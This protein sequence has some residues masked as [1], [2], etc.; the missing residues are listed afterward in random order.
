MLLQ[1]L[2]L[3]IFDSMKKLNLHPIFYFSV[4]FLVLIGVQSYFLYNTVLLKEGEIKTRAK[5]V[6]KQAEKKYAFFDNS[7]REESLYVIKRPKHKIESEAAIRHELE[8]YNDSLQDVLH[9]FAIEQYEQSGLRL[10][11]KKELKYIYNNIEKDTIVPK[12]IVILETNPKPIHDFLLNESTWETSYL[13]TIEDE[14]VTYPDSKENTVKQSM[15]NY[16]I[17]QA[18]YYDVLNLKYIVFKELWSLFFVSVLLMILM[19]YLYFQ[20]YKKYKEQLSQVQLLH[21]TIDNISHEFKT[22]LATLRIATK[23]LRIVTTTETIDIVDRQ[24]LRLEN[25]LKPLNPEEEI[26]VSLREDQLT[27]W[28][29]DYKV[30]YPNVTW[31]VSITIT[32]PF[33]LTA[34]EMQT[35]VSNLV[36]NSLKYGGT[37]VTV[38]IVQTQSKLKIIVT[39]NGIGID[40]KDQ[41]KVFDRFY[42]VATQNVHNVKGLGLGLHLVK[43]I[44]TNYNGTIQINS[45]LNKGCTITVEL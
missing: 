15:Q 11:F 24:V 34:Y 2:L 6:L 16:S 4:L 5:D 19:L 27:K 40:T 38:N 30:F 29:D 45:N 22:P 21:D 1:T 25:V 33:T 9:D 12:P 39:D 23:Q 36:E 31:E 13:S 17:K 28:F 37:K 7:N 8:T 10:A 42:R 32:A 18:A 41:K 3:N 26:I 44:I 43:Q 20:S 35:I 14:V